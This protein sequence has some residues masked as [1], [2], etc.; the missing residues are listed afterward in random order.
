MLERKSEKEILA[1]L[2]DWIE[3]NRRVPNNTD[4]RNDNGL[5]CFKTYVRRFG[6]LHN[7]VLRTGYTSLATE[8]S[9]KEA[10][11][12]ELHASHSGYFGAE[13]ILIDIKQAEEIRDREIM[14]RKLKN[15]K[16]FLTT[17]SYKRLSAKSKN[18]LNAIANKY[19]SVM[20]KI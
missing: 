7:A 3:K 10:E 5:Q 16:N 6:S 13:K 4:M 2:T 14:L 15:L 11:R 12:K 19:A 18:K 9:K 17:E 8:H 1:N 20:E